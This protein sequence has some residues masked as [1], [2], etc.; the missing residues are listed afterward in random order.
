[1]S[2]DLGSPEHLS[3]LLKNAQGVSGRAHFGPRP[4]SIHKV[5]LLPDDSVSPAKFKADTKQLGRYYAHPLTIKAMR[6][7]LFAGLNGALEDLEIE[8]A[9]RSCSAEWDLQFWKCCPACGG[10]LEVKR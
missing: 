2:K 3:R 4:E 1:M 9:C 8:A 6:E 7:D 10:N 5:Q